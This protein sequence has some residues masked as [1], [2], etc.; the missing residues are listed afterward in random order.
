MDILWIKT[1]SQSGIYVVFLLGLVWQIRLGAKAWVP[2]VAGVVYA[3]LF[4]HFNMVR[5]Q[6]VGS[7]D[8]HPDSWFLIA[9]DVPLYIPLAWAFIFATSQDLTNRLRLT[10]FAR[11]FSDA[12]LTLLVD[13]SLDL[14]A[15]RLFF[16]RW[17]GVGYYDA[18]FGVPASNFVGWLLVTFTFCG[19]SR[20]LWSER[21]PAKVNVWQRSLVQIVVIPVLAYIGYLILE[22]VVHFLN[23]S[24]GATSLRNQLYV[25]ASILFV[26]V[27]VIFMGRQKLVLSTL[28]SKSNQKIPL[29]M[30]YLRHCFH[31]FGAIGLYWIP[32]VSNSQWL[33]PV[34]AI[35]WVLEIIIAMLA[36]YRQHGVLKNEEEQDDSAPPLL[37]G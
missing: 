14:V 19:L 7:Y 27:V 2:Y 8:Y 22:Q 32:E 25:L 16:W 6:G 28:D 21:V 26:F 5:F 10:P 30:H 31:L 33:L 1:L 24:T 9:G 13:L 4:E 15:I 18:F 17:D 29:E 20:W 23:Q 35:V 12:I 11:P 36:Y 34:C 37:E 3:I